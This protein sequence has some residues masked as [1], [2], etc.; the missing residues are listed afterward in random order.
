MRLSGIEDFFWG[1]IKFI[2]YHWITYKWNG[3]MNGIF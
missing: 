1:F 3:N 2:T